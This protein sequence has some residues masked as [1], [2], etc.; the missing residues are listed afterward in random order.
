MFSLQLMTSLFLAVLFLQSGLDKVLDRDGNLAFL[1][2]HFERSPLAGQVDLLLTILT[3][4]EVAAGSFSGLGAIALLL[5]G[6]TTFAW[7]GAALSSLTVLMLF[8]GQRMARE[9]NGA[10]QLVPYFILTLVALREFSK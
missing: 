3:A 4:F 10:A 1:R 6:G 2:T 5:W 7:L 8:F 9:Y